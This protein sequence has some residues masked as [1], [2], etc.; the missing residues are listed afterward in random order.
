LG[1]LALSQ[2]FGLKAGEPLFVAATLMTS[3]TGMAVRL[4]R[5]HN[6]VATPSGRILIGSS[7]LDDF[8]A[9]FLL[10]LAF[11]LHQGHGASGEL[12]QSGLLHG[13][14]LLLIGIVTLILHR[15]HYRFEVPVTWVLPTL[16]LGAWISHQFGLTA[17]LGALLVGL[18]FRRFR[19]HEMLEDYLRPLSSFL[20]PLYFITVGMRVPLDA[21]LDPSAWGLGVALFVLALLGR[22]VC[23]QGLGRDGKALGAD[24]WL[25]MW[26]MVPRGM[27][28]LVFATMAHEAGAI[29]TRTFF[30]LILMVTLSNLIGLTGMA[31][32]LRHPSLKLSAIR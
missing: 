32:R 30:A 28:G 29:Q 25:V 21:L 24:P 11:G 17:L 22:M 3:G 31:L 1:F 9:I 12:L 15:I 18:A 20:I 10:A 2:F 4:L 19:G 6:A 13:G 27:P 23:L 14:G 8:P 5:D 16:V 26:G 7:V